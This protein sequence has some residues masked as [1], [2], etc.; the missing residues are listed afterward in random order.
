MPAID[1]LSIVIVAG[2]ASIAA[3]SSAALNEA[4]RTLPARPRMD[5]M[6]AMIRG[7]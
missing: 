6:Y 7:A 5:G 4:R 1:A 3:R 2:E